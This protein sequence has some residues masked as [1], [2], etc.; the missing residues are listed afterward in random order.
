MLAQGPAY[1]VHAVQRIDATLMDDGARPRRKREH[2]RAN[3]MVSGMACGTSTVF[4]DRIGAL[5][6]AVEPVMGTR[7]GALP[8]LL[9]V[10]AFIAAR[11]SLCA[12]STSMP[13]LWKEGSNGFIHLPALVLTGTSRDMTPDAGNA[14]L[15]SPSA[16]MRRRQS[17]RRSRQR[18][19]FGR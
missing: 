13:R 9:C 6:S 17:A 11:R 3:T 12:G 19:E 18:K 4:V 16:A 1:E 7:T 15:R 14:L 2:C 8:A 10:A 5:G